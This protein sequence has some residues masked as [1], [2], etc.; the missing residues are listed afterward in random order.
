MALSPIS[1]II[2]ISY[3]TKNSDFHYFGL[4]SR[5]RLCCSYL[6]AWRGKDPPLGSCGPSKPLEWGLQ[7]LTSPWLDTTLSSFHKV[8]SSMLHQR[9]TQE[10]ERMLAG[11]K[12]VFY[13]LIAD[14]T[15]YLFC[16]VLLIWSKSFGAVHSQGESTEW[17]SQEV[18]SL[19]AMSKA[20][21]CRKAELEKERGRGDMGE[22][23]H[24]AEGQNK[25][26][27]LLK[28][29]QVKSISW[30]MQIAISLWLNK[31]K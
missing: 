7:F 26:L 8:I 2:K 16:H 31:R 17:G 1:H 28:C 12:S 24:E 22:N 3:I 4:E 25:Y 11:Q 23:S 21:Y 30:I 14:S 10:Q 13:N 9:S 20:A 19:A 29:H 15:F 27:L 18:V 6:K 5:C